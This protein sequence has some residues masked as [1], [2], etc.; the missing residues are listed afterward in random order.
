MS[1]KFATIMGLVGIIVGAVITS[2]FQF[3][4]SKSDQ[5]HQLRMA[6]LEKRLTTHQEAYTLWNELF[7]NIH[8]RDEVNTIAVKCQ[9]WWYKNCLYLDPKTRKAFK[10]I[11]YTASVFS[12]MDAGTKKKEYN[13]ILKVGY[14]IVEGVKLPSIGEFESKKI[15]TKMKESSF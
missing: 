11:I 1:E 12:S 13:E 5:A 3:F 10:K 7:W 8:N 2:L 15:Q 14:L 4:R 9:D 6:A